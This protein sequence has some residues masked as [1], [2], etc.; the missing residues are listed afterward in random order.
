MHYGETL[1]LRPVGPVQ[2]W[3]VT[4]P[5]PRVVVNPTTERLA[6][7]MRFGLLGRYE[8]LSCLGSGGNGVVHAVHDHSLNRRV[9]GKFFV[10]GVTSAA[11]A[12]LEARAL[13]QLDHANIVTLHDLGVLHGMPYLLL[14][15]LEGVTLAEL[16][17]NGQL[18]PLRAL[19]IVQAVGSALEHAHGRGVFHFAV[20]PAN[21]HVGSNGCIKV[22]DFGVANQ[23]FAHHSGAGGGDVLGAP[24]Y[25]APEQ[26][27]Q[28]TLDART[29]IW[30]LGVLLY[31]SLTGRRPER[32]TD[33]NQLR[34]SQRLRLPGVID[35]IL[36]R[37]LAAD[38]SARF[39]HVGEVLALLRL[40][41]RAML[42]AQIARFSPLER[43]LAAYA[44]VWS[45]PLE[46]GRLAR[47][48]GQPVH[49][50]ARAAVELV[51]QNVFTS[52]AGPDASG[53][54]L[55][56]VRVAE[57]CLERLPSAERQALLH[58]LLSF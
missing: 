22:L 7:G 54:R 34:V 10:R 12:E 25:R 57:I 2:P 40:A 11:P 51:H 39:E 3:T 36:E 32:S 8:V 47:A 20:Q 30:G 19:R 55:A 16:V 37:T 48:S 33:E 5:E 43:Q 27:S 35:E 17:A 29:D 41:E 45:G 14:E 24:S 1:S 46:L 13:A 21:V 26:W 9:A 49:A 6:V 38:S 18:G 44:G 58:R 50:A 4:N 53:Y 56:D 31:E 52:G 42:E 28:A 15:L 23:P